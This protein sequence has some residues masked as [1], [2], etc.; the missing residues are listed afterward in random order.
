L[1]FALWFINISRKSFGFFWAMHIKDKSPVHSMKTWE[2]SIIEVKSSKR[3]WYKVTRRLPDLRVSET[4]IFSS[5]E[6]ARK[7]FQEWIE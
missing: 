2:V 3:K 6:K 1:L 5:K 4:K 7:Q